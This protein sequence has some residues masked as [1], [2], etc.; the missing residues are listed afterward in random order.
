MVVSSSWPAVLSGEVAGGIAGQRHPGPAG[1]C[2]G[3]S[4]GGAPRPDHGDAAGPGDPQGDL[5]V[6][7]PGRTRQVA[8]RG[9]DDPAG[10]G[11]DEPVT[12][13]PTNAAVHGATRPATTRHPPLP[14]ALRR[15]PRHPLPARPFNRPPAAAG[16][17]TPQRSAAAPTADLPSNLAEERISQ[18]SSVGQSWAP[19]CRRCM[20]VRRRCSMLSRHSGHTIDDRMPR[21]R[22]CLVVVVLRGQTSLPEFRCH[23]TTNSPL[24]SPAEPLT[25]R[26]WD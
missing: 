9:A 16:P 17:L 4:G 5:H 22:S 11:P 25:T 26:R 12:A 20:S 1:A 19:S 23:H 18:C 3:R 8:V 6:R 2:R 15:C 24:D 7:D 10:T 14:P 21:Q 13:D